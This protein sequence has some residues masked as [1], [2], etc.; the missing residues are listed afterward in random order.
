MKW[1]LKTAALMTCVSSIT[2]FYFIKNTNTPTPLY[3]TAYFFEKV[4]DCAVF[5]TPLDPNLLESKKFTYLG[6]GLQSVAFENEDKTVVLKFFIKNKIRTGHKLFLSKAKSLIPFSNKNQKKRKKL[7]GLIQNYALY[8]N[9]LQEHSAVLSIQSGRCFQ[10]PI[11]IQLIDPNAQITTIDLNKFAFVIQKKA[12]VFLDKIQ[13]LSSMEEKKTYINLMRSY[14]KK[15]ASHGF[16]DV[17]RTMSMEKNYGFV[18]ELPVQF[19]I[20]N[21]IHKTSIITSPQE[22]IKEITKHFDLFLEHNGLGEFIL[23]D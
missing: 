7:K 9:Q 15:R 6:Q 1:Y 2:I 4:P 20:G 10:Q 17:K 16:T 11:E 12:D 22:E 8:F 18:K 23:K 3:K 5:D 13:N 19:D 21:V 14:L